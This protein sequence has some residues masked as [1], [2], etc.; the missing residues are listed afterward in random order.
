MAGRADGVVL[1]VEQGTPLQAIVDAR[2]R[3]ATVGTPILGYVFNRSARRSSKYGYGYGGS[4]YLP[5]REPR[6]GNG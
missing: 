3:I 1:V 4:H 2:D 5:P 6:A